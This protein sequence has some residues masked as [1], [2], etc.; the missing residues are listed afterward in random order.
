[1]GVTIKMEG[2]MKKLLII[3]SVFLLVD[4]IMYYKLEHA[5]DYVHN[6]LLKKLHISA[7]TTQANQFL[8]AQKTQSST[9]TGKQRKLSISKS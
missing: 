3:G 2:V 4:R 7:Q 9:S 8:I 6:Q 1:M 5:R